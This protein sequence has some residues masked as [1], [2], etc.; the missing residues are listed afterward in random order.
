[1]RVSMP[2]FE[3]IKIDQ[4]YSPAFFAEL[5]GVS[6]D[7]VVRMFQDIEGVFKLSNPKR[8]GRRSRV[9]LRIPYSLA[10]K[11]YQDRCK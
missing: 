7:T 10:L 9:E 3:P 4:H 8:N 11:V 2:Q 5:W 1:M 6:P